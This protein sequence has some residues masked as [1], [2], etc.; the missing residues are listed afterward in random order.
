MMKACATVNEGRALLLHGLPLVRNENIQSNTGH[1]T[2]G[3]G[4]DLLAGVPG[5]FS[6]LTDNCFET[7]FYP[8]V[9]VQSYF[10]RLQCLDM[11]LLDWN[12]VSIREYD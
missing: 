1:C 6:V 7:S 9:S 8:G 11:K 4:D 2:G 12:Y 3:G 10:R 5:L